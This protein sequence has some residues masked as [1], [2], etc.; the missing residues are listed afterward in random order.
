MSFM[1]VF[2]QLETPMVWI[3]NEIIDAIFAFLT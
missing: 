1:V 2:G 3:S